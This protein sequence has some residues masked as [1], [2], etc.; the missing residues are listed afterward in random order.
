MPT[1]TYTPLAN[2]T[3]GSSV[4]SV[5]F[6]SISQAYRDLVIV[7]TPQTD[8]F[9][10]GLYIKFNNDVSNFYY[11]V[12]GEGNGSDPNTSSQSGAPGKINPENSISTANPSMQIAVNVFDYSATDK[13]KSWL[14]RY[15]AGNAGTG[16]LAGRWTVTSAIT[17][18][19]IVTGGGRVFSPGNTFALYGIAA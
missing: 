8:G 9:A 12:W 10:G 1:P 16:M 11:W 13:H 2:I 7:T 14:S 3:L 6:S 5:T 19:Q 18:V 4:T 17:S 15:G